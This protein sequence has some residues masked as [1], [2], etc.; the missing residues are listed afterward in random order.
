MHCWRCQRI[1][2]VPEVAPPNDG[3]AHPQSVTVDVTCGCG[4]VYMITTVR[5]PNRVKVE[6]EPKSEAEVERGR[7]W[8]NED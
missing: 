5:K 2:L 7:L 3:A 1:V 8:R 4:A 6:H